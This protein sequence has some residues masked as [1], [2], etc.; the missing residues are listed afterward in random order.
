MAK[1]FSSVVALIILYSPHLWAQTNNPS[2][3]SESKRTITTCSLIYGGNVEAVSEEGPIVLYIDD[4]ISHQK[5]RLVFSKKV[6]KK[7]SY[8]PEKKLPNHR[9]CISGKII[10]QNGE[11]TIIIKNEKQI[12]TKE[13]LLQ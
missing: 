2:K 6:R 11:P 3:P 13:E 5:I 9:A 4:S 8:D 10:D 1:Y 12:E 7:F